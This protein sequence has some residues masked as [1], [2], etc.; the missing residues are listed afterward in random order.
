MKQKILIV[1]FVLFVTLPSFAQREYNN[2]LFGNKAG[3]TWN[4]T[5][6]FGAT[7]V[8]GTTLNTTLRG[9]PT[10]LANS[11]IETDE[12]C[13][14]ISDTNGNLLF[15]SDGMTVWNRNMAVMP[16]GTGLSGHKSSAQSGVIFPFP[17]SSTRYIAITLGEGSQNDLSYSIVDMNAFG[18]LGQLES[19][20]KNVKFQGY[21]GVLGESVTVVRH[22]NK[23][24][25]WIIAPGKGSNTYINVWKATSAGV[26]HL[27][28]HQQVQ[29]TGTAAP[30]N[31]SLIGSIKFNADGTRFGWMQANPVRLV[32]GNFNPATGLLSGVKV[33]EFPGVQAAPDFERGYG[34]EFSP[35]GSYIYIP[36]STS[37][38]T[39]SLEFT[40]YLYI[41]DVEQLSNSSTPNSVAPLRKIKGV[42]GLPQDGGLFGGAQ[43][44]SDNRIYISNM[45]TNSLYV[46]DNPDDPVNLRMYNLDGLLGTGGLARYGLPN[47]SAPWFKMH[48]A[49]VPLGINVCTDVES[50]YD[51]T[52]ENGM[53]F[54]RID[55]IV[56]DFGDGGPTQ[57]ILNPDVAEAYSLNYKYKNRGS[58]TITATAQNALGGSE[59]VATGTATV[60][61]CAIRVN[62]HIRGVNK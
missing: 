19:S 60:S 32:Y 51:V 36:T 61:S 8:F 12:G 15:F 33:R 31:T 26:T 1:L 50:A 6:N 34:L 40:S 47:L 7:G 62:A 52:F 48:V 30:T 58:Y 38:L 53:G 35:N 46:L 14:V 9:I 17:Q 56:V 13:F 43:I 57:T 39:H 49:P 29:V 55:R 44:G 20:F 4:T 37:G 54:N 28:T 21:S 23:E 41:F 16:N 27:T 59:V 22:N 45:N 42:R 24:D 3:L 18:G 25:F 2:W 5:R 10:V 11:P